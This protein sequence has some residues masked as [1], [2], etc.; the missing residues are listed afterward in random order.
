MNTMIESR[1][2]VKRYG[3]YVAVR[4]VDLRVARGS[5]FGLFGPNG[6]GK[7]TMLRL[8]LDLIRPT[9]GELRV[10][11]ESPRADGGGLRSTRWHPE[12]NLGRV[13]GRGFA[14]RTRRIGQRKD[15]V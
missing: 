6:A 11:G 13:C 15:T 9:S 4:G 3:R 7:T 2:L 5:V 8:L 10:L 12:R 1:A 14:R